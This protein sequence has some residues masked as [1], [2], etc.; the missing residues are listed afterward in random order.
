MYMLAGFFAMLA[1]LALLGLT[2][3][4]QANVADRY[5]LLPSRA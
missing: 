4:A 3:S 1:G 5:T 2:T